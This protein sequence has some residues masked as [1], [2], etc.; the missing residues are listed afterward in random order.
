MSTKAD[1]IIAAYA[2]LARLT[3]RMNRA[4]RH[5]LRKMKNSNHRWWVTLLNLKANHIK[6][7]GYSRPNPIFK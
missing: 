2:D 5:L 3:K 1:K 4:N 7:N 6:K